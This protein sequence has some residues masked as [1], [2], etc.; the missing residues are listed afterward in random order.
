MVKMHNNGTITGPSKTQRIEWFTTYLWHE[1][2]NCVL[3]ESHFVDVLIVD[4]KIYCLFTFSSIKN[5]NFI[6]TRNLFCFGLLKCHRCCFLLFFKYRRSLCFVI[7]MVS[8]THNCKRWRFSGSDD[9]V[10]SKSRVA[11]NPSR[12]V[13]GGSNS[14]Y[15]GLALCRVSKN[16]FWT[17]S[18]EVFVVIGN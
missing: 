8:E 6:A 10:D 3:K 4:P 9:H 11:R 1:Y 15:F 13:L 5:W 2:N 7:H 18:G 16:E 14:E 12:R 17:G